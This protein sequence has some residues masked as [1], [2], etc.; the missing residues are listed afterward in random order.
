MLKKENAC[1]YLWMAGIVLFS[2]IFSLSIGYYIGDRGLFL[3]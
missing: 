1:F 3:R 2:S